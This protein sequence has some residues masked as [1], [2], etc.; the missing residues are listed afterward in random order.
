[1]AQRVYGNSL[2]TDGGIKLGTTQG[3]LDTAFGHGSLSLFCTRAASTESR[4]EQAG[5]A[6][7][8]P[9]AAQQLKRR[10]GQW[11]VAILG[12][13]AAVDMDHHAGAMDVGSFEME[14]LVKSQAAR[15]DG[16]QIG[17]VVKGFDVGQK[18]SDLIDA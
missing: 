2:F 3:A 1:M 14:S 7:G 16:G 13:L 15:I 12:A 4:E 8:E 11:D 9:I 6:V 18:A 17:V 10:L 5:V